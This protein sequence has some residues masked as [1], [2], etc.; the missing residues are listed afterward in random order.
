MPNSKMAVCCVF[1]FCFPCTCHQV[2]EVILDLCEDKV[3]MSTQS[4]GSIFFFFPAFFHWY[5]LLKILTIDFFP[6]FRKPSPTH[7]SPRCFTLRRG[8]CARTDS[9]IPSPKE[10]AGE[11]PYPPHQQLHSG[12]YQLPLFTSPWGPKQMGESVCP[13]AAAQGDGEE[14]LSRPALGTPASE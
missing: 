13:Q 10:L 12:S 5:F 6:L 7:S 1:H 2:T 3:L 9:A 8:L 11:P 4:R 14:G